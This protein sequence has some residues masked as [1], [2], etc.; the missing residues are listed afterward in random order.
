MRIILLSGLSNNI[1][2]NSNPNYYKTIFINYIM[3]TEVLLII[4]VFMIS[5]FAYEQT[6]TGLVIAD[7]IMKSEVDGGQIN[8]DLT[9]N[10]LAKYTAVHKNVYFENKAN[11]LEKHELPNERI[12]NW[13]LI[14]SDPVN[15]QITINRYLI[16][17]L[18]VLSYI[19]Q[20][21]NKMDP[22]DCNWHTLN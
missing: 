21:E 11:R 15:S 19:C 3:K 16:D 9:F 8:I 4:L 18:K 13:I 14:G 10:Q 22:W 20:K 6:I 17:E 2:K 1:L 5:L 7:P 12:G